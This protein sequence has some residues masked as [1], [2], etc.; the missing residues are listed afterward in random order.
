MENNVGF[1][2]YKNPD[3]DMWPFIMERPA[4]HNESTMDQV[5]TIM[6][7]VKRDGDAALREYAKNFDRVDLTDLTLSKDMLKEAASRIDLKLKRAI[8]QSAKNIKLFHQ[9]QQLQEDPVETMAG[10]LCFREARPIEKVG[11]YVPGGT[12]PLFSSVLMLAIPATIAGCKEIVLTTPPQKEGIHPAVAYSALISGVTQVVLSGGAQGIA[13]LTY[14]TESVP[15]VHKIFGPGNRYVTIAKLLASAEGTA[16]DMPAG[17]SEVM[18]I[19]DDGADYRVIAQDLLSQAEHGADSQCMF[20][21]SSEKQAFNVFSY[22]QGLDHGDRKDMIEGSLRHSSVI[23]LNEQQDI[24]DFIND[25][26][27]EHLILSVKNP[28]EW[29]PLVQNSGSV[30]LGYYTPESAG[31]YASGTNHTLPTNGW[32]KMYSG[33]NLGAYT[34]EITFQ[35]MTLQGLESLGDTIEVMAEAEGLEAHK[36]AVSVRRVLYKTEK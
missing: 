14:G 32:A 15:K 11:I 29:V 5:R 25:Y 36:A 31:D 16:I 13:A 7:R 27:P 3:R 2:L 6:D 35:K 21:T 19:A 23:V 9:A 33:V 28:E 24:V 34:K 1:G 10:V 22:I 12:A 20:V 4:N 26:A 30:F 17:P 18:V 8:D